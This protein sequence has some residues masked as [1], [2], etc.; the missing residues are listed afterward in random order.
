MKSLIPLIK[1]NW[2]KF[3]ASL[4]LLIALLQM[5][6]DYY[7]FLRW[8]ITVASVF[9][10]YT[11]AIRNEPIYMWFFIVLAILF[12]PIEPFHLQRE[13]WKI[14]D[15]LGATVFLSSAFYKNTPESR[16]DIK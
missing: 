11:L 12:N 7:Q 10:V 8:F 1:E 13:T 9:S 16:D 5:P 2:F 15:I 14:I 4:L 6:Y 3:L